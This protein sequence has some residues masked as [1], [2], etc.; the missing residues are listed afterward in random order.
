MKNEEKNSGSGRM[1]IINQKILFIY[2]L[3]KQEY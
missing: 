3:Q 1:L 2:K